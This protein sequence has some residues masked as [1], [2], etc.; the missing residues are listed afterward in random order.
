MTKK[1]IFEHLRKT[2]TKNLDQDSDATPVD[3]PAD[4]TKKRVSIE[5]L[6]KQSDQSISS[7]GDN[8]PK[9]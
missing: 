1:D 9:D 3:R 6:L 5:D 4:S 7:H 8:S 2:A